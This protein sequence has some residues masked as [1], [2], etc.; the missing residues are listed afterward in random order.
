MK[1]SQLIAYRNAI[2]DFSVSEVQTEATME[3]DKIMHEVDIN[4]GIE[5]SATTKLEHSLTK[6]DKSFVE[7]KQHLAELKQQI[8]TEIAKLEGPYFAESYRLYKEE[9]SRDSV[10]YILAR[11]TSMSPESYELMLNRIK[12][13]NDWRYPGLIIRPGNH[14]F[15]NNMV[16]YDPL[17]LVDREPDLLIPAIGM[18]PE[19]YQ[20]R[21]R[22]YYIDEN[23]FE[24]P[25]LSALPNNQ[26][27]LCLAFDFFNFKPL[28]VLKQYLVEIYQKLR[29][30]GVLAMTI[31]DCDYIAAMVLVDNFFGC[32]TPGR[33]VL[34][35]AEDIGF[36]LQYRQ[37]KD[38]EPVTWLELK[39]PGQLTSLRGGQ[40]L[41]K[42]VRK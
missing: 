36:E 29:P 24:S 10:D 3:L 40:T 15:I 1:L 17:Y 16:N 37:H 25:L 34:D 12:Y 30:G 4:R 2:Q 7:F 14:K 11:K 18:F 27:G 21:L 8:D 32:Y 6:I 20:K 33:L 9:I 42:L 13:Y 41:A 31:N 35:F 39:K 5:L 19:Q 28:E 22:S 23:N 26:F 38:G